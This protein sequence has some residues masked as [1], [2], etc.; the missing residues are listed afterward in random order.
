MADFEF[1]AYKRGFDL[2]FQSNPLIYT[3]IDAQIAI[4]LI[5]QKDIYRQGAKKNTPPNVIHYNTIHYTVV[6]NNSSSH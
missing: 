4:H 2:A 1:F 3:F 6:A 5:W